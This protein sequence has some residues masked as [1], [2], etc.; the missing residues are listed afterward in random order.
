M[1]S[2]ISITSAEVTPG[3][4]LVY[5]ALSF[6]AQVTWKVYTAAAWRSIVKLD[7][8]Y[9]YN[10]SATTTP[11]WHNST[12][13]TLQACITQALLTTQNKMT[14]TALNALVEADYLKANG[15]TAGDTID[16]AFSLVPDGVNIPTLDKLSLIHI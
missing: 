2:V 1:A 11:S 9:Q 16:F 12:V 4:S 10:D 6:D 8:T 14:G 15:P 3:S 7:T 13:Q 5:H